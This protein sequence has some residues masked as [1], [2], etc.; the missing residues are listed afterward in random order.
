M[1]NECG[2]QGSRLRNEINNAEVN[3]MKISGK[4][5]VFNPRIIYNGGLSGELKRSLAEF[6]ALNI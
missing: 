1:L 3:I 2:C 4:L 6:D 5:N